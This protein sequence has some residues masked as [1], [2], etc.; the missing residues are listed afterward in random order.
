MRLV[1]IRDGATVIQ[2][3]ATTKRMARAVDDVI[4]FVG[5][6]NA[7]PDG[8][9]LLTGAGIIV[10][11]DFSLEPD[12]VVEITIEGIGTLRNPVE[13]RSLS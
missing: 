10:P 4:Q 9:F 13:R 8:L 2:G 7:Y 6:D 11:Q 3:D 12:D 1:V 5:R